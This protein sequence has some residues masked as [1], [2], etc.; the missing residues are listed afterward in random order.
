[1][2]PVYT[3]MRLSAE[4]RAQL[5]TRLQDLIDNG[6]APLGI[7]VAVVVFLLSGLYFLH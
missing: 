3:V 2:L 6:A 7:S 1:M 4:R 5:S